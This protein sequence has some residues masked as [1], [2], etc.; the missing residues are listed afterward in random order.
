MAL[1][2]GSKVSNKSQKLVGAWFMTCGGMVFMAVVLGTIA[3]AMFYYGV[4]R[5][6]ITI[7]TELTN[8]K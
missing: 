4:I 7:I 8:G 1:N 2:F 3:Y 5:K 6:I